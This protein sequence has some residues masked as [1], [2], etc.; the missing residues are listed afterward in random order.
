MIS[1]KTQRFMANRMHAKIHS[2]PADHSPMISAPQSV[3]NVILE[4]AHQTLSR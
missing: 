3:I 2:A 4:A 1:P